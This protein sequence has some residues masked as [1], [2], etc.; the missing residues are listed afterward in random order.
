MSLLDLMTQSGKYIGLKN[1]LHIFRDSHF[2][3]S[4]K[5][6]F[7]FVGVSVVGQVAFGLVLASILHNKHLKG[8]AIFRAIFLI[9]WITTSVI[10]AYSWIYILDANLGFLPA[11]SYKSSLLNFIGLGRKDWLTNPSIVIYVLAIINIWKGT[12]FSILMQSA[13]LQSIPDSVYESAEVDGAGILQRFF[14]ITFPLL[15]PFILVNLVMTTMITFNVYDLILLITGGGPSHTSEVLSLFVYNT[16]FS[17]GEL[18][19]A[20]ALSIVLLL[21]N[22]TVTVLY[23]VF[24][25]A[26]EAK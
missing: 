17:Q 4:L 12:G 11:L 24:L 8:R 26:R 9:P 14:F 10:A 13:G 6:S 25:R 23:L 20:A 3:S 16:G 19:Y 5:N 1:Y 15:I 7:T 18:G 21:I 2:W 22:V